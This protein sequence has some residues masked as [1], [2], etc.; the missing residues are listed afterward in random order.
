MS[1]ALCK[2]VFSHT[3]PIFKLSSNYLLPG[4]FALLVVLICMCR[5]L[6]HSIYDCP[7]IIYMF[8]DITVLAIP[9]LK[10]ASEFRIIDI[11]GDG[12]PFCNKTRADICGMCWLLI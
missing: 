3:K 6:L 7:I 4:V 11:H 10:A 8:I 1:V 12:V 5:F 9:L 2:F